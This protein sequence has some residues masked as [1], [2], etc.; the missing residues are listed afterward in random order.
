MCASW[1][2][3]I[4]KHF[5][6]LQHNP[7]NCNCSLLWIQMVLRKPETR[8]FLGEQAYENTKLKCGDGTDIYRKKFKNCGRC[9]SVLPFSFS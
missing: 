1:D 7:L 8:P 3:V 4:N 9:T 2:I 6:E 5:R